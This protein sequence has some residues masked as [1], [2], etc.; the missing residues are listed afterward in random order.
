MDPVTGAVAI[1]G[2]QKLGAPAADVV[3][4]FLGR[5]LVM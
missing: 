3:E 5:L 4:D 2:L 1:V